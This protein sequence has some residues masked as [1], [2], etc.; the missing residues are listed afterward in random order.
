MRSVTRSTVLIVLG[1]FVGVVFLSGCE[2]QQMKDLRT[3][4][5]TQQARIAELESQLQTARLQLDQLR[6]QLDAANATGGVEVDALRQKIAALEEDIAK[7]EELI[8]AMQARLMG[9][10]PLPVE[11]NT[12]LEDFAKGNDMVEYDAS[13]GL[14][15]FKSDLLFEKGSDAVTS[16]AAGAVKT[17]CG[18][19]NTEAAKEFH[20]IVAGHTDDIP[21]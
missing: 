13:R 4:N 2:S 3:R 10:S 18:I 6:K 15:K 16:Q 1:L 9:V 17:L 19:L 20:I 7:K 5:Q 21:I 12:A 11:L 8:K 14:V